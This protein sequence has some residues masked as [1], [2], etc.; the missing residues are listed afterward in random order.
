MH[1]GDDRP[2]QSYEAKNDSGVLPLCWWHYIKFDMKKI[3][4]VDLFTIT[5]FFKCSKII[6]KKIPSSRLVYFCIEIKHVLIQCSV[7]EMLLRN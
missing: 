6:E 5:F 1:E 4:V 2:Q 3:C 7:F